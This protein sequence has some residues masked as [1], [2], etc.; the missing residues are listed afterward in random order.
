ML[1]GYLGQNRKKVFALSRSELDIRQADDVRAIVSRHNIACI[2]NCAGLVLNNGGENARKM[3]EINAL[4]PYNIAQICKD[5]AIRLVFL[6]SGRIFDGKKT[7][8]Y[9]ESDTPNP[10]DD[11]GLSKYAGE[12]MVEN[13]LA[14]KPYY[15]IR[16]PQVLGINKNKQTSA[17]VN[18]LIYRAV[19]GDSIYVADDIFNSYSYAKDIADI[20]WDLVESGKPSGI[21]H[22]TNAGVASLHELVEFI[23]LQL[24]FKGNVVPVPHD[25]FKKE[26]RRARFLPLT[27]HKIETG[28]E[29]K[30]A[31]HDFVKEYKTLYCLT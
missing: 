3:F 10:L 13:T 8:L 2:I 25:Y 1:A 22:A 12:K 5:K 29:W 19:H 27:S 23:R 14:D 28:R 31:I 6:S 17:T 20:I 4:C 30:T 9:S 11:Y 26:G 16:L 15:I 21:Y 7:A 24:D 18:R